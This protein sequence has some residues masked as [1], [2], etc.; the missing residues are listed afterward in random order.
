M[1]TDKLI[2]TGIYCMSIKSR[3]HASPQLEQPLKTKKIIHKFYD[4]YF[5]SVRNLLSDNSK[6]G[7]DHPSVSFSASFVTRQLPLN[8][9]PVRNVVG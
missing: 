1:A 4:F 9:E 5:E 2:P 3:Q 6:H 8:L 7:A